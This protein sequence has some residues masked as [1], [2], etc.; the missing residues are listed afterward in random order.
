MEGGVLEDIKDLIKSAIDPV[1]DN[2]DE[3]RRHSNCHDMIISQ[4]ETDIRDLWEKRRLKEKRDRDSRRSSI[5]YSWLV[6]SY[7]CPKIYSIPGSERSSLSEKGYQLPYTMMST[8]MKEYARRTK[9]V[10]NESEL[11]PIMIKILEKALID[12]PG[13]KRDS[14]GGDNGVPT[15]GKAIRC[16]KRQLSKGIET[17]IGPGG[18][19]LSLPGVM[20]KRQQIDTHGPHHSPLTESTRISS[21]QL[22]QMEEGECASSPQQTKTA[23]IVQSKSG[24]L[25]YDKEEDRNITDIQ[26]QV[27][28][29]EKSQSCEQL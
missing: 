9:D 25:C 10:E 14:D 3:H 22:L 28:D 8:V 29:K 26:S 5:D 1:Q 24:R 19:E 4:V 7:A 27:Y 13:I 12:A 15:P 20:M 11:A 16:L 2:R 21:V 23:E 18:Q 6:S 17:Y